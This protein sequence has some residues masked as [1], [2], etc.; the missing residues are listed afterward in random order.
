M[1]PRRRDTL[2]AKA[3]LAD[4][5]RGARNPPIGQ[6]QPVRWIA[7]AALQGG[8]SMLPNAD[9]ANYRFQRRIT[10]TLPR[11]KEGF[12][13]HAY[14][15]AE[16][17][18]ALE[19]LSGTAAE[20]ARLYEFGAGWDLIGPLTN[21]ALGV[22]AQ[23]LVDIRHNVRLEL[24]ND[25]LRQ[26]HRDRELIGERLDRELRALDTE[27]LAS[28]G[29]LQER[30]GIRYLA[31][32]DARSTGLDPGSFDLISSTF[33]MEHIQGADLA[34]ILA[35]SRRLLAPGGLMSSAIDMKDHYSYFDASISPYNFLRF[36]E[37]VWWALNP[38]IHFQNRLRRSDY[39]RLFEGAGHAVVEERTVWGSEDDLLLV[40]S[41]PPAAR[42]RD[43]E[44]RDRGAREL[45]IATR[46]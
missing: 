40:A 21:C 12:L 10:R 24:V 43:Y 45:R 34:A 4:R 8:I 23:T 11:S 46:G 17:I 1:L 5:P 13:Q 44:P 39:L 27:P 31:P 14:E 37:R 2:T 28:L 16:H 29:E 7:K 25:T 15:A 18:E 30:F 9:A 32:S 33:T 22:S 35:E 3:P 20:K 6:Y 42:F 36:S 38:P 26:L 41:L 19:R